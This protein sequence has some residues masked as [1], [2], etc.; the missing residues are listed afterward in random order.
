MSFK[1]IPQ[2]TCLDTKYE[3]M[4]TVTIS[5]EEYRDLIRTVAELK[6]IAEREHEDS[7]QNWSEMSKCKDKIKNLENEIEW[8]EDTVAMKDDYIKEITAQLN[9]FK[10]ELT[11]V[12]E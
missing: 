8:Y 3:F 7:L 1:E 2:E 4:G 12:E 9:A 11:E 10:A 6:A 5:C